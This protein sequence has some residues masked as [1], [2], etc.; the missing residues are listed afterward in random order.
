MSREKSHTNNKKL[1]AR[2][3]ELRLSNNL[4]QK[5]FA[6]ALGISQGFIANVEKGRYKPD[7]DII[8]RIAN[9]YSINLDWLLTG[10]G[11]MKKPLAK[12]EKHEPNIEYAPEPGQGGYEHGGEDYPLI[13][14][15]INEAKEAKRLGL[16]VDELLDILVKIIEVE[17]IKRRR[18]PVPVLEAAQDRRIIET[19]RD[20]IKEDLPPED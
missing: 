7:G 1:G 4:T 18:R 14:K 6:E 3:K 12:Y 17:Q 20:R 10:E 5:A 9:I 16:D 13:K 2:L 19:V 8:I 15:F 11:E